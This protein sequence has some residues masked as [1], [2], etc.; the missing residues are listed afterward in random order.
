MEQVGI[1][2][3]EIFSQYNA[4]LKKDIAETGL[5]LN[6]AKV[7]LLAR[8]FEDNKLS[9]KDMAKICRTDTPAM[10]RTID[11]LE[12]SG[13]I[14][15]SRKNEDSR[16]ISIELSEKGIGMSDHIRGLFND[17]YKSM[18]AELSEEEMDQLK[19]L[20]TKIA[21]ENEMVKKIH[22]DLLSDNFIR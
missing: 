12:E 21:G 16:C 14:I 6:Q 5:S 9:Q 19:G 2:C 8:I 17:V 22:N 1:L 18:F 11:K 4:N 15:R 7:L 20:L 13:Y 10:S 3:S